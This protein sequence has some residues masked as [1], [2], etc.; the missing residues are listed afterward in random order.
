MR[1]DP[2]EAFEETALAIIKDQKILIKSN[3]RRVLANRW[4]AARRDRSAN[5]LKD[6]NWYHFLVGSPRI[7]LIA[8]V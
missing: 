2:L 8:L 4:Q 6:G 3:R 1:V 7:H 5:L